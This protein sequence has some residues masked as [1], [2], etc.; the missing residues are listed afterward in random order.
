MTERKQ[1]I[2]AR[3]KK[4]PKAGDKVKLHMLAGEIKA[5]I[6]GQPKEAP[7]TDEQIADNEAVEWMDQRGFR[8]VL[9][10]R[11]GR[12]IEGFDP[13]KEHEFMRTGWD[14]PSVFRLCDVH[15]QFN[16]WGLRYRPS[17]VK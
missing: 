9:D 11:T 8:L 15:P 6:F 4:A 3:A 7:P 14:A 2:L 10:P 1:R 12:Y 17:V 13:N 5:M 16:V